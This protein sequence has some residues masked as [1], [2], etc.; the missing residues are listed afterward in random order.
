MIKVASAYD[1]W[2]HEIELTPVDALERVHQGA[3]YEFDPDVVASLR[4]VLAQRR[5]I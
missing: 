2:V 3:A 1:Q 4:H 5:A